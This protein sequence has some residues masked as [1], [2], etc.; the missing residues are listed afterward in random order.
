[1]SR[2][3]H[4]K[5]ESEREGLTERVSERLRLF[6]ALRRLIDTTSPSPA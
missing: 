4:H 5:S 2:L 6:D 3:F 1:M